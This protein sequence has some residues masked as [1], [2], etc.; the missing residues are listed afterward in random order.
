MS[1][2]I[3]LRSKMLRG[4]LLAVTGVA[5]IVSIAIFNRP[6]SPPK[7]QGVLLS[8]PRPIEPFTLI[9]H[10]DRAFTKE[11]FKGSWHLVSYGFATCPDICP[12]TLSQINRMLEGIE[13]SR[14]ARL[15]VVFYTVD[16]KRDTPSQM[17]NYVP[18]FNSDFTGL[19]HRDDPKNLH[20]PFERSL[21]IT[22]KLTP[23]PSESDY[24]NPNDYDVSH[25]V[26]LFLVNPEGKLQAIFKP[27]IN[28]MGYAEFDPIRLRNDYLAI[29]KYLG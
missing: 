22:A 26:T 11:N 27:D 6:A 15:K 16:H 28:S 18:Y 19:T 9:D 5:V 8:E 2:D 1:Q 7:I 23:R 12:T 3:V 4:V 25:G 24:P 20:L 13:E 17:A 14:Y 10:F 29:R 21:G